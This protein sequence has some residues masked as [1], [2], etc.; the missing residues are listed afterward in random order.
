MVA[1]ERV[2]RGVRRVSLCVVE[3]PYMLPRVFVVLFFVVLML[4]KAAS[5]QEL[6][7]GVPTGAERATVTGYLDGDKFKVSLNRQGESVLMAGTD[8]PEPGECFFNESFERVKELL[9]KGTKVWLEKS[10]TDRDN[11]DRLLRYVWLEGNDGKKATLVNTKLVREGY[12]G[13]DDQHDNPKYYERLEELQ[14][15]AQEKEVGVWEACGALHVPGPDIAG[16]PPG[17]ETAAVTDITDGDTIKVRM[18]NGETFSVRLILIDTP[19]TKDPND[20]VECYGAEAT[21]FTTNTLPVGTTVY[22]ETDVSDTDQ[23]GR[24]LRYIWYEDANGAAVLYNE[25]AVR[26]GYAVLSTYPPDVKYVDRIRA[27]Q[28][29]AIAEGA[30]LWSVCGGADTPL[31]PTAPPVENP[32]ASG[33]GAGCQPA[34]PDFCIPI[35]PDLDCGDVSPHWFTVLPPDPY[36][37]DADHDGIGCES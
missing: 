3:L 25:Q 14:E 36:R 32:P 33:P 15:Q 2:R 31:E 5:A 30:G 13:F 16:L 34:Y 29:A 17:V 12:A 35:G 23:Y 24:Q 8:A 11:S 26:A 21:A 4:P 1:E 27:A 19:E 28:D 18:D 6:P 9:P 22:L 10:G 20:P 37:F 7:P